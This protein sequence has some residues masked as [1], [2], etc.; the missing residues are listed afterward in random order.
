MRISKYLQVNNI[1]YPP[2]IEMREN[3]NTYANSLAC[4]R[5]LEKIYGSASSILLVTKRSIF[6]TGVDDDLKEEVYCVQVCTLFIMWCQGIKKNQIILATLST[7]FTRYRGLVPVNHQNPSP[8][9]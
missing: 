1:S 5:R 3:F 2:A 7:N 6:H 9:M 8:R 4:G